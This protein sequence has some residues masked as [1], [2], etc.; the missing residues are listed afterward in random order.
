MKSKWEDEPSLDSSYE[1]KRT[2]RKGKENETDRKREPERSVKVHKDTRRESSRDRT[3]RRDRSRSRS[4][5]HHRHHDKPRRRSRSRSL[6]R[7]RKPLSEK[8]SDKLK[9]KSKRDNRSRDRSERK[10]NISPVESPKKSKVKKESQSPSPVEEKVEKKK[11]KTKVDGEEKVK[12]KK[13]KSKDKKKEKKEKAAEEEKNG[14]DDVITAENDDVITGDG[15]KDVNGKDYIT[16]DHD[17][18]SRKYRID[19]GISVGSGERTDKKL[20]PEPVR[21][22]SKVSDSLLSAPSLTSSQN[23]P[24]FQH[25]AQ[26]LLGGELVVPEAPF[27][28]I[29][30]DVRGT[31]DDDLNMPPEQPKSKK[32]KSHKSSK[33]KSRSAVHEKEASVEQEARSLEKRESEKRERSLDHKDRSP[34]RRERPYEKRVRRDRD[35]DVRGGGRRDYDSRTRDYKR[36]ATPDRYHHRRPRSVDRRYKSPIRRNRTPDRRERSPRKYERSP[37]RRE[38]SPRRLDRSPER[39]ERSP[40]R[41]ERSP[42]RRA[43]SPRADSPVRQE[44]SPRGFERTPE[45]L[46]VERSLDESQDKPIETEAISPDKLAEEGISTDGKVSTSE[47]MR[48]TS[49]NSTTQ[50]LM[51]IAGSGDNLIKSEEPAYPE[52]AA[53]LSP[54]RDLSPRSSRPRDSFDR[55][56]RSPDRFRGRP[57]SCRYSPRDRHDRSRER[58]DFRPRSRERDY[59]PRR[60]SRDVD[61]REPRHDN[62]FNRRF[63]ADQQTRPYDR[64]ESWEDKVSDFICKIGAAAPVLRELPREDGVVAAFDP[65]RPPPIPIVPEH[66]STYRDAAFPSFPSPNIQDD[67][68]LSKPTIVS[69]PRYSPEWSGAEIHTAVSVDDSFDR[70]SRERDSKPLTAKEK[71]K[72]A[73][74][75]Q[76]IWQYVANK[77][78][79]DPIFIKRKKKR[80]G[81]EEEEDMKVI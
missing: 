27:S 73:I 21:S 60:F 57:Y 40:R 3:K 55:R 54:R 39:R 16:S 37:L 32:S 52:R 9:V 51:D 2:P 34:D 31:G 61:Y 59:P 28:G 68:A 33:E 12:K 1:D 19:S 71:K 69:G 14:K 43:R 15:D 48:P 49:R 22:Q 24:D 65:S 8:A 64:N 46:V 62:R 45:R 13:K 5:D 72:Q 25:D 29:G 42:E 11:K 20:E 38:R 63:S 17:P 30:K 70:S 77:L 78:L 44:R 23:S 6:S 80:A 10:R 79:D 36:G 50:R 35:F 7:R 26:S 56:G 76:E 4:R 67:L 66:Q 53:K 47:D 81:S 58:R 18:Q 75:E 41:L 74:K